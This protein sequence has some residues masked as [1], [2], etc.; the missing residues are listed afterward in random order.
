MYFISQFVICWLQ[1]GCLKGSRVY[2]LTLYEGLTSHHMPEA[3]DMYQFTKI[4]T[5]NS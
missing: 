5:P 1:D 3:G 2:G 4:Y